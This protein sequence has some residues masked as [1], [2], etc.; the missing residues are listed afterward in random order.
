MCDVN[1]TMF[2]FDPKFVWET[3]VQLAGFAV[4]IWV[5]SHQLKKQRGMQKENHLTQIRRDIYKEITDRMEYSSPNGI[6]VTLNL[7]LGLLAKAREKKEQTGNYLPPPMRAETIINDF[8][9]VQS[10]L[11][12]VS[13]SVEKYEI[14]GENQP[15]F[16]KALIAKIREMSNA[17]MPILFYLP[18]VLLS[19]KGIT[20]PDKLLVIADD[21]LKEFRKKIEQFQ[22]VAA[23]V[24]GF[25]YD[26]QVE[27]QNILLGDLFERKLE[28]RRPLDPEALVLTSQD[29]K[30]LAKIKA[31]VQKSE[32]MKEHGVD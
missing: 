6:S 24:D 4:V 30:Q 16:R 10:R 1:F 31:F 15:L 27:A 25:L 17:F 18:Y 7:L 9:R 19:D 11:F 26:I 20:D 12:G 14:A 23:D 2:E 22:N 21:E 5:M 28:V 8:K 32:Q 29:T 13:G 3:L